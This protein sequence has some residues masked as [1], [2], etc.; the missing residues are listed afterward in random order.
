MLELAEELK[1]PV[2][3]V[4]DI[5]T[6]AQQPI[7]L[8]ASIGNNRDALLNRFIEDKNAVSPDEGIMNHNLREVTNSA[9]QLLSP[10]EQQIVRMRYGLNETG[11][12]YTLQEVGGVFKV[13]RERIRQIEEKALLKLRRPHRSNKLRDFVDFASKN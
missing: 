7:S 13:T 6:A 12:E 2:S 11:K 5:L 1:T 4:R 8:E 3:N 9:L 10:R